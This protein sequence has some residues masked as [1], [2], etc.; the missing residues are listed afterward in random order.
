MK[1]K[2]LDEDGSAKNVQHEAV[3]PATVTIEPGAIVRG[4]KV[5]IR[6]SS[7]HVSDPKEARAAEKAG[8]PAPSTMTVEY[9]EV[10][11]HHLK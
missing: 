7:Y 10:A 9:R 1:V 2:L 4:K 11:A 8:K 3:L 6:H 5:Y